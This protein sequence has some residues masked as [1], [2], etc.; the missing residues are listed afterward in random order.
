MIAQNRVMVR[1]GRGR[2]N[3]HRTGGT[4]SPVLLLH[5]LAM[6]GAVWDPLARDLA[7]AGYQVVA[8]DARGH[9]GSAWDGGGFTVADLAADA[10]AITEELGIGP[11]H[12]VG[13]SMGGST[14]IVLAATR[15]D[16]VGR[17]LLADTTACYGPGRRD[18]W[19]ERA[20]KAT[21]VPR[22]KQLEFQLDRWFTGDFPCRNPEEVA[23]VTRIFLATD[24]RAHAAACRALG[25]L[26][27]TDLLP[28]IMAPTLVLVGED[29]YATPPAMARTIANAVPGARLLVVPGARHFGLIERR[30]LW[31]LVVA[32][33]TGDTPT[34]DVAR[35]ADPAT[36]GA[37][38]R[39]SAAGAREPMDTTGTTG[40]AD[41][42]EPA[43][44]PGTART[45]KAGSDD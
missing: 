21:G 45:G 18:S 7:A 6:A 9:G 34:Q 3:V 36:A 17:L 30:D 40:T 22:E 44:R 1:T 43:G 28:R 31:P 15:P 42:A 39:A 25:D 8:P 32:H 14:A 23:R 41:A 4:G 2:F 13:L 29:D 27:A 16:L 37:T 19:A 26:D 38:N 33:L 12:V 5:P 24:S 11:T 10:A 35:T 20:R